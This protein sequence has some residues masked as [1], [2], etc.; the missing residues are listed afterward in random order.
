MEQKDTPDAYVLWSTNNKQSD[1]QV[2]SKTPWRIKQTRN[3]YF[4]TSDEIELLSD[5]HWDIENIVCS[6]IIGGNFEYKFSF[7]SS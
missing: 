4:D 7:F 3:G 5:I 2:D 6:L 1:Y